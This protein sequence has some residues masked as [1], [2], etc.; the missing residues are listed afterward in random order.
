MTH[1]SRK[2][3]SAETLLSQAN[4]IS[5]KLPGQVKAKRKEPITLTNYTMSAIALGYKA[6]VLQ[7]TTS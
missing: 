7:H 3:L 4:D 1:K 5:K 6:Q 2:S